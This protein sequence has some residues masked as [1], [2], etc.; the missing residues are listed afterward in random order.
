MNFTLISQGNLATIVLEE[1]LEK[2]LGKMTGIFADDVRA[3]TGKTPEI[4][5]QIPEHAETVILV[6]I[7]GKS[8]LLNKYPK[9]NALIGKRECYQVFFAEDTFYEGQKVMVIA[10]SDKR[11]CIYGMFH[12][13]EAMGVS[14]WY[15]WADATPKH[16]SEIEFDETVCITSPEPSVRYR[17]L[18]INDEQPCFGN[19]A[20][21][22]YGSIRPGPELY[23]KIFE[24]ILR[25][26]GNY[27]WPAMWRSD[28]TLDH[29]ENARLAT[30]MGIVVG[31]SH[32]EPCCRSGQE[33]QRL[34]WENPKYGTEWSFLSNAEGITEFWK[35]GLIRNKDFEN[36]ITIGMRGEN[37]SYL[38]PE[39]ATLEDNINV[40]KSAIKVQKELISKYAPSEHPQL[41]A[42]YKEVEDYFY[43]DEKTAGLKDWDV[44]KDD[45]MMLCDDNFA[46]VRTL[47][48][49]TLR[50]HP[51]GF[52]MYYHFDYFGSPVSYLWINTSP[53]AKVWEQLTMAYDFGIQSAWIVNVGDIKNQELPLSYF[54][55]LAY[56][57]SKWGTDAINQTKAY[58]E[59]FFRLQG[60]DA[61]IAKEAARLASQYVSINGK[62]R[63]EPLSSET[64]HPV[65][66]LEA[67]RML[68]EIRQLT[69]DT[70]ALY[71]KVKGSDS[72]L[73]E[74]FYQLLYYP[75]E[76]VAA[77]NRLQIYAGLNH[78]YAKQGKKE[79]NVFA[80][81]VEENIKKER[82]LVKEYHSRNGGKWNHMQSVAHIGYHNWNEE[83]WTYPTTSTYYPLE[84]SRLLVSR[85]D[86][87]DC[88]N[89]N[90]WTRHEILLPMQMICKDGKTLKEAGGTIEVANG[91]EKNLTYRIDW[92][93]DWIQV[94]TKEGNPVEKNQPLTLEDTIRYEIKVDASKWK[95]EKEAYVVVYGDDC[96]IVADESENG[97]S[98]TKVDVKLLVECVDVS[99]TKETC[100]IEENGC[101]SIEAPHFAESKGGK[102]KYQVLEDYG[103]TVGGIKAYPQTLR[104]DTYEEAPWVDYPVFAKETGD[105][106]CMLYASA[107]N[108]AVYKGKMEVFLQNNDAA[109]ISINTIPDEGFVPWK[110]ESW[111]KGVLD[112]IHIAVCKLSL[113]KGENRI[114]IYAKDPAVVLEKIVLWNPHVEI[115]DSYLGPVESAYL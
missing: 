51:G 13:S 32:H 30:E 54:M 56:D 21:E 23:E 74:C 99:A 105:Y 111:S 47:P 16:L 73:V 6:G 63:P 10:G 35:D 38:M 46:N 72:R 1:S 80:K 67:E 3:V 17:G 4:A 24:L 85:I 68:E 44:L 49:D 14:P 89:A 45:I 60:F 70:E 114:R 5:R 115:R 113:Q 34:R 27:L 28:F 29:I 106:T 92:E 8:L 108:P 88:T 41:L 78:L 15:F 2:S 75:V 100:F 77:I 58:T 95:G 62:R 50:K 79:A 12:I 40:L 37:D 87:D 66:E 53:L 94:V 90:R 26:K 86:V 96:E 103:K 104:F 7:T 112:Q 42:I 55:D 84:D 20:K 59:H 31:S 69:N 93:S 61:E 22:K 65:H 64:Y 102:A 25:L 11:G 39:D 18:F 33:F 101:I 97:G 48:D 57:F 36:L 52:G 9:T 76:S 19:W 82:A 109:P 83:R 98:V 43:G 71:E 107:S 110:S 81:L 91:G